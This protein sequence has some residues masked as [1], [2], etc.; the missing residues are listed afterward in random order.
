MQTKT[1]EG[2]KGEYTVER[3]SVGKKKLQKG[4][5]VS[6]RR[7]TGGNDWEFFLSLSKVFLHCCELLVLQLLFCTLWYHLNS[8]RNNT[9]IYYYFL[10]HISLFHLTFSLAY[11]ILTPD[12]Q[13]RYHRISILRNV[14]YAM[15]YITKRKKRLRLHA[16][17]IPWSDM[18]PCV[19][20]NTWTSLL[21]I[22]LY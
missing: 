21:K 6:N 8:V 16:I 4:K 2:E 3:F 14:C 18:Q 22:C 5:L 15:E 17:F 11:N 20:L 13:S 12:Q 7:G 10:V 19:T 1:H 9:R